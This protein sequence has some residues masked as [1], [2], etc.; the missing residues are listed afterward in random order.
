MF[1][2][3]KSL[4]KLFFATASANLIKRGSL[5]PHLNI[6]LGKDQHQSPNGQNSG[7]SVKVNPILKTPLGSLSIITSHTVGSNSNGCDPNNQNQGP[8]GGRKII[9]INLHLGLGSHQA[10]AHLPTSATA[11]CDPTH[12]TG[13]GSSTT[14][15]PVSHPS[16]VTQRPVTSTPTI[17]RTS[18]SSSTSTT[19]EDIDKLIN[20]IFGNGTNQQGNE[21]AVPVTD[22]ATGEGLIDIRFGGNSTTKKTK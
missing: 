13:K 3:Q 17:S 5:L 22:P 11:N 9:G 20:E 10:P 15:G 19:T 8:S 18:T 7:D 2:L 1:S 16:G 12:E 4:F 21:G 14:S 6:G